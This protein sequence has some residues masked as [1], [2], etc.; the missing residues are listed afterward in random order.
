MIRELGPHGMT[1]P[2]AL[3]VTFNDGYAGH[4]LDPFGARIRF[5]AQG[6]LRRSEFGISDGIPLPG[7]S[8]GVGDDVEILI[9]AESTRPAPAAAPWGDSVAACVCQPTTRGH[10]R[11]PGSSPTRRKAICSEET[12]CAVGP[13]SRCSSSGYDPVQGSGSHS[14]AKE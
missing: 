2:V 7:S 13:R 5:S 3:D 4:P 6:S 10:G 9:E 1:R 11:D 12:D 8:F 14:R